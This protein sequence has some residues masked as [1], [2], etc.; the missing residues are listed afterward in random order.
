MSTAKNQHQRR[1]L[2]VAAIAG[3]AIIFSL[4]TYYMTGFQTSTAH[5]PAPTPDPK[6]VAPLPPQRACQD[7]PR[8]DGASSPGDDFSMHL[9]KTGSQHPQFSRVV[10]VGFEDITAED[11]A[12][13]PE[14]A[15]RLDS[16]NATGVSLSIGRLDW[17]AFPW[18][19]QRDVESS[20]VAQTGR[21]YVA[22]AISAFR[23]DA[24]GK[25][26]A[27]YLNID[28]LLGRELERQPSLSGI[29][30]EG[31]P[32]KNWASISAWKE[33]GLE[34]RLVELVSEAVRR[35]AP[36]GINVTELMFPSYT[37]GDDDLKNFEKFSER[38]DWPRSADGTIDST[39]EQIYLWRSKTVTSIMKKVA[40][41][42][43]ET[44]PV[45]T[46]DVRSPAN[47]DPRGRP[48]SGQD[49]GQ[50]LQVVDR[51][52]IW[53]FRGIASSNRFSTNELVQRYIKQEPEKYS[54]EIGLW[55][56]EGAMGSSSVSKE[57]RNAEDHS[58]LHVSITPTSLMDDSIWSVLEGAWSQL[59]DARQDAG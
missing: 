39:S 15:R 17:V 48:D 19:A 54:L 20:E 34:T 53:N 12:R 7:S 21:D 23:C 8:A 24:Q 51:L 10:N 6:V 59:P 35:Y 36:D 41:S 56:G 47:E 43:D 52:N 26:R 50:L 42:L 58:L 22:E 49:Y 13:I 2:A 16:V 57:L 55:E 44:G 18:P 38:S 3:L 32:S 5:Q 28:T 37:F 27:I 46:M 31:H 33:G 4:A 14:I 30:T 1:K 40:D 11:P 45:L 25:R 9:S 29:N